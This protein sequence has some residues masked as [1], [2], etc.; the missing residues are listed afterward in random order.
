MKYVLL[1]TLSKDWAERHAERTDKAKAKLKEL[2][3]RL[4]V[5]YYT[6]GA[7]DFVD[8]VEAPDP[9]A[10]LAFSIWYVRQ[11]FGRFQTMPAFDDAAM[12][13]ALGKTG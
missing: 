1:G 2:N 3:I 9:D 11:G 5:V 7:F 8:I 6:Q 12:R 4:E 10:M 13:A